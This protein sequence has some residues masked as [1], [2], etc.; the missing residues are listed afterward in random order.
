MLWVYI[1]KMTYFSIDLLLFSSGIL[2]L[3]LQGYE[4]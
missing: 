4:N 1:G 2:M 3:F